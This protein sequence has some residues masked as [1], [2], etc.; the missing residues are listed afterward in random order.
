[1]DEGYW[2]TVM[3]DA[4]RDGSPFLTLSGTPQAPIY[5]IAAWSTRDAAFYL[6]GRAGT[7]RFKCWWTGALPQI[8]SQPENSSV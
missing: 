8:P 1:M 6:P 4:P 3:T 5:G 7:V 2:S